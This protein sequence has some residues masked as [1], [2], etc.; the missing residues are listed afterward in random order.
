MKRIFFT[1][2][3]FFVIGLIFISCATPP[4]DEMNKAHDAVTQAENDVDA[5]RYAGNVL[6]RA[7][8][9][10]TKM[11]EEVNAKRYDTAKNFA[12]EAINLAEKAIA[13]GRNA[14]ARA[15]NEAQSLHSSLVTP[16]AETASV[17]EAA[18]EVDDLEIDVDVLSEEMD[19]ALLAYEE[20]GQDIEDENFEE[21][22]MKSQQVRSTL[23]DIN[24]VITE[25]A[26]ELS[27]KQ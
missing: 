2:S 24:G 18:K 23:A 8:E 11:Q 22:L 7:R 6:I 5:V 25:A 16:M 10:L 27:R 19:G 12:A 20:A 26:V 1:I 17:L 14:A 21:S 13:D 3:V 15:R 4:T 9:T